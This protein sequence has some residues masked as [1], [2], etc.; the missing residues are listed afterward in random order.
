MSQK[1][2]ITLCLCKNGTAVPIQQEL[3]CSEELGA[4]VLQLG[5]K[6]FL[7]DCVVEDVTNEWIIYVER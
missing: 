5:K 4:N 6:Y 1:K 2:T 7:K 3:F